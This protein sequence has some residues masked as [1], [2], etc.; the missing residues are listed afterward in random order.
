MAERIGVLDGWRAL[1]VAFVFVGHL[2]WYSSI[3]SQSPFAGAMMQY[4]VFGVEIFFVIS[5][6]VI[7]RGLIGDKKPGWFAAFYVRR[8]FRIIPPFAT[9]VLVIAALVGMGIVDGRAIKVWHGLFF[10]CNFR[11]ETC[12]GWLGGH[13]WSLSTEEQFYLIFP[14][15]LALLGNNRRFVLT[16]F[17]LLLPLACI[18]LYEL[19]FLQ[20][21]IFMGYSIGI[22]MGVAW[23]LNESAVTAFVKR[24]PDWT[25]F[26]AAIALLFLAQYSGSPLATILDT[27]FV[28]PLIVFVLAKSISGV[29]VVTWLFSSDPF[30]K[31]GVASYGFYLW[32]QLATNPFPHA[33]IGFY[34][35]SLL[36]SIAFTA[37][38]YVYFERPLI[39]FGKKLSARLSA[40]PWLPGRQGNPVAQASV[41]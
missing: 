8:F 16:G 24:S 20:T 30:R 10:V 6:F 9:Y 35:L 40:S 21:A 3:G 29:A 5:G 26:V 14:A 33:G 19:N 15:T 4:A 39:S 1:S 17:A 13:F 2:L 37:A 18:G 36:G 31:A 32:Q 38:S 27:L 22:S 7:C 11:G 12:G 25:F 23:A 34:T 41:E 28:A